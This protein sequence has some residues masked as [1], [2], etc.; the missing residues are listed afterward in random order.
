MRS[1][2]TCLLKS[3][4]LKASCSRSLCF[5]FKIFDLVALIG[6]ACSKFY[7][8]KPSFPEGLWFYV[9]KPKSSMRLLTA[10]RKKPC[11]ARLLELL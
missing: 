11:A 2:S 10:H 3:Q 9:V 6:L 1:R 8:V 4:I 7:Y 5:A